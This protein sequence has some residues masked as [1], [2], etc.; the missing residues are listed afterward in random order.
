MSATPSFIEQLR[1]QR[2]TMIADA[3]KIL[4]MALRH[5]R[6]LS[7]G[8]QARYDELV[9]NIESNNQ[10]ITSMEDAASRNR[11]AEDALARIMKREPDKEGVAAGERRGWLPSLA[12]YRQMQRAIGTNGEY[13]PVGYSDA[14]AYRLQK[15]TAVLNAKPVMLDAKGVAAMKLP[16]LTSGVN[17][18]GIA[19]SAPITESDPGLAVL[20]LDPKKFGAFTLI[21]SEVI[22]DSALRDI[23]GESLIR[24]LAVELGRQ[25]ITGDGTGQNLLGLR[26]IPGVTSGPNTGT[27]GASLNFGHLADTLGAADAANTDPDRLA[28]FMHART[29]ASV[30]KLQD[31]SSRPIVSLDPTM[32]VRPTLWGKPVYL[33][34]SLSVTETKG[35]SSDCSSIILAD[36]SQV[37][38]ACSREVELQMSEDFRFN[39]DEIALRVTCRY[40]IG[41][42][43]P[44]AITVTTGVRP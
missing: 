34:N 41:A 43:Q 40:D 18:V 17:V 6:D 31:S 39:T 11:E 2:N 15:R 32:G 28:W 1:D 33:D 30:R 44:A 24:D 9:R 21:A 26:N 37:L 4:N 38:V 29:W 7:S 42:T 13:V 8:E 25:L 5:K 20:T 27:N 14:F 3:E 36:M 12:E 16:R 35:T 10:T 22:E 23:I 19:E